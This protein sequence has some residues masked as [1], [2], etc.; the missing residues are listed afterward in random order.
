MSRLRRLSS[1]IIEYELAFGKNVVEELRQSHRWKVL[2]T[3]VVVVSVLGVIIASYGVDSEV[4]QVGYGA[5]A[6]VSALGA[7]AMAFVGM[8][9]SEAY[10]TAYSLVRVGG[11]ILALLAGWYWLLSETGEYFLPFLLGIAPISGVLVFVVVAGTLFDVINRAEGKVI[12]ERRE[13]SL[14]R[15]IREQ[16]PEHGEEV[17]EVLQR[18]LQSQRRNSDESQDDKSH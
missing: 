7:A 5:I 11:G 17:I 16:D 1:T 10:A 6:A 14:M 12:A 2:A 4:L 18:F 9:R 15:Q 13:E 3:L 8:I